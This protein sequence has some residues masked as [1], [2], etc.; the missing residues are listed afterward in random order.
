MGVQTENEL[1]NVRA[2]QHRINVFMSG[3]GVFSVFSSREIQV[4]FSYLKKRI[5]WIFFLIGFSLLY[6]FLEGV[7]TLAML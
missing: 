1:R 6:S 3:I 2:D 7:K 4:I 5:G